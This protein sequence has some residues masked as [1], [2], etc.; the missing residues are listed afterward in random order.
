[1]QKKGEHEKMDSEKGC[2]RIINP[3]NK[4]RTSIDT[5]RPIEEPVLGYTI[6]PGRIVVGYTNDQ[7]GQ[8]IGDEDVVR[9]S[10][11]KWTK[12]GSTETHDWQM[13]SCGPLSH[14][15]IL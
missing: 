2:V 14:I 7:E 12:Q 3:E 10:N 11:R 8:D 1:M 13:K 6:P 5:M 15:R 9:P 4:T